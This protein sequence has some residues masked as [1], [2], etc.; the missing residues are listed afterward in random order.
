VRQAQKRGSRAG[1]DQRA[2]ADRLPDLLG[3]ISRKLP[4]PRPGPETSILTE[5]A[6]ERQHDDG[7][8]CRAGN[9]IEAV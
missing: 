6:S 7:G 4:R 2:A 8:Q 1:G 9:D 3:R 5:Y